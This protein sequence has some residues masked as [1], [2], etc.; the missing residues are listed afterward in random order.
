MLLFTPIIVHWLIAGTILY[1]LAILFKSNIVS[2]L[3]SLFLILP[4]LNIV[5]D[6]RRFPNFFSNLSFIVGAVIARC[7]EIVDVFN[8]NTENVTKTS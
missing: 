3:T 6:I 1:G 5:F 8:M 2:F 7:A 4:N